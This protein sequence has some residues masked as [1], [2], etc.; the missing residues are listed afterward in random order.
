MKAIYKLGLQGASV[1]RQ[2]SKPDLPQCVIDTHCLV[3]CCHGDE[4]K[5]DVHSSTLVVHGIVLKEMDWWEERIHK[6]ALKDHRE[7]L[8]CLP[9]LL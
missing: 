6:R 8:E 3:P 2:G 7:L 5:G 9:E 4:E 1:G